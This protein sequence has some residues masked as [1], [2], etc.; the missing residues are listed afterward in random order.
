MIDIIVAHLKTG[1]IKNVVPFGSTPLP[2]PPYV[3]VKEELTGLGFTRYRTIAHFAAG[4]GSA[5][6][7]YAK[8]TVFD[9]LAYVELTGSGGRRFCL[10]PL[11]PG[12]VSTA[13]SDSTISQEAVFSLPEMAYV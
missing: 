13:N 3:V 10:T 9:L 8:K 7:T 4:Q 5:M 11:G 2:A 12:A 6:R 1:S